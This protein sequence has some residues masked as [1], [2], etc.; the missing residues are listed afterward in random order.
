MRRVSSEL[1]NNQDALVSL[2]SSAASDGPLVVIEFEIVYKPQYLLHNWTTGN[3][4]QS[5]I[6]QI[7]REV[8]IE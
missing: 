8:I 2:V 1:R 4:S 5:Y 6:L 7:L 3:T